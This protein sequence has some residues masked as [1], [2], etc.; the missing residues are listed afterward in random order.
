ME[1][2]LSLLRRWITSRQ[3]CMFPVIS[4]IA[5]N[6]RTAEPET[7]V[8]LASCV[9]CTTLAPAVSP[10]GYFFL[11]G[12]QDHPKMA[13]TTRRTGNMSPLNNTDTFLN[14]GPC[15]RRE[16]LPSQRTNTVTHTKARATRLRLILVACCMLI[17]LCPRAGKTV[18]SSDSRVPYAD[19]ANTSR[20]ASS[21]RA[22]TGMSRRSMNASAAA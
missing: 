2:L 15:T 6:R 13:A 8:T 4:H 11:R 20:C 17:Q 7:A 22:A 21:G 19:T 5:I 3:P 10:W 18:V 14:W 1:A 12:R 16:R 9:I